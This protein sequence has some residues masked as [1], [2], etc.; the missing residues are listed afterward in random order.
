MRRLLFLLSCLFM[1]PVHSALALDADTLKPLTVKE[2][3]AALKASQESSKTKL[4]KNKK[5]SVIGKCTRH[6]ENVSE[7]E[8][9]AYV[10]RY[11]EFDSESP[12][13]AVLNDPI[14]AAYTQTEE[15]LEK[16]EEISERLRRRH[17]KIL[18]KHED[19]SRKEQ[20]SEVVKE[21]MDFDKHHEKHV[22][23][24]VEGEKK[25]D[26]LIAEYT[27]R[28]KEKPLTAHEIDFLALEGVIYDPKPPSDKP[29]FTKIKEKLVSVK[30]HQVNPVNPDAMEWGM[31]YI[32]ACRNNPQQILPPNQE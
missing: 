32:H 13:K 22:N 4:Q 5:T 16:A 29:A 7:K 23:K 27:T 12:S 18:E 28:V 20:C 31:A 6:T 17:R 21:L 10:K 2:R 11:C 15:K 24:M 19:K 9:A 25:K 26:K 14:L 3:V 8:V 30:P 1:A